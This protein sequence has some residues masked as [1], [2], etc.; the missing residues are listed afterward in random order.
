MTRRITRL[1]RPAEM[2]SARPL[3][4]RAVP[5]LAEP[6]VP[7]SI[8]DADPALWLLQLLP[9]QVES[10]ASTSPE[11]ALALAM[12]ERALLDLRHVHL[13]PAAWAWLMT[14]TVSGWPYSFASLCEAIGLDVARVR[15]AL[16]AWRERQDDDVIL[17]DDVVDGIVLEA[18]VRRRAE[19]A[20]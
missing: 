13:A 12:I 17:S 8:D 5:S 9:A 15:R 16:C 18:D 1:S 2:R 14:E 10:R 19:G 11:R 20:A 4:R 6:S 3:G 7:L